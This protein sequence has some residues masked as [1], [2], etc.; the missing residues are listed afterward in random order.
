MEGHSIFINSNRSEILCLIGKAKLTNWDSNL[1]TGNKV[2]EDVIEQEQLKFLLR[3]LLR[4]S[5][6]LSVFHLSTKSSVSGE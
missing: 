5:L 1:G 4:G 6:L 2:D 3:R